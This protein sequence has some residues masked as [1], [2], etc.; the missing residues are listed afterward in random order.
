MSRWLSGKETACQCKR[1]GRYEFDPWVGRSPEEGYGS[2][3]QY[4]C[5]GNPMDRGPLAGCSPWG[6]KESDMTEYAC[7]N[8]T[9]TDPCQGTCHL[10]LQRL[11]HVLL[12]QLLTF[13]TPAKSFLWR[14][15]MRPSV[16]WKKLAGLVVRELDIFR[17]CFHE[18]TSYISL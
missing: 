18:P 8:N 7:M 2:I 4:S 3:S 10:P 12:L 11:N 5:L 6:H 9:Q 15:E 17:R 14:A 16:L 13:S 1:H